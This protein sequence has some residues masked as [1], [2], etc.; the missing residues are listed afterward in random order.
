MPEKE[1]ARQEEKER[2]SA[3]STGATHGVFNFTIELLAIIA[4]RSA[5]VILARCTDSLLTADRNKCFWPA[6]QL[7]C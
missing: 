4:Q 3:R 1:R 7:V 6:A 2:E 5:S